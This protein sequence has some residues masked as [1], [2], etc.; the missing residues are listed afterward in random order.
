MRLFRTLAGLCTL[1]MLWACSDSDSGG[2]SISPPPPPP[3]P[4]AAIQVVH[5][6][7]NAPAVNVALDGNVAFSDV[8]YKE[9]PVQR[10]VSGGTTADVTVDA[11]LPDDTTM[12]VIT[13]PGA[14]FEAD[15]T[16]TIF[17]IGNVG[18]VGDTEL[19]A[20]TVERSQNFVPSDTIRASAVHAAANAPDV[21][22]YVSEAGLELDTID[23]I[24]GMTPVA[25]GDSLGPLDI[26]EGTLQVRV[27]L[28]GDPTALVFDSGPIAVDGG[29]DPILAA[30]DNTNVGSDSPI[31]ILI[32]ERNGVT[33]IQNIGT[34]SELRLTH[35]VPDVGDVVDWLI[36]DEIVVAGADF[37]DVE[38]PLELAPDTYV[39]QVAL[40]GM[41]VVNGP[42]VDEDG[43]P[44]DP[45]ET[46][47]G[48]GSFTDGFAVGS[49]TLDNL[50]LLTASDDDRRV[51]TAGKLRV[52]HASPS[53]E[54]VDLYVVDSAI[55]DITM[56][57]PLAEDI[58]YL[59]NS[60]YMEFTPGTYNIYITP[61][62]TKDIAIAAEGVD[63]EASGVYTAIARDP[64]APA[65]ELG[66]IL[67][68]DFA[69]N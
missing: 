62:G 27:T 3:P 54:G 37:T 65:M 6:S 22:I 69:N 60:G 43:D 10:T 31:S 17:A 36:D 66:L 45:V 48:I 51:A 58:P 41:V 40:D 38:E 24:N 67:M 42:T 57:D 59:F 34:Q 30:V 26:A 18:D 9:V 29:V 64:I 61:T 55:T 15:I 11:I 50:G 53:T 56:E 8:D 7:S 23:P 25:F 39:I 47:L 46:T 1:G 12:T 68:D 19:Q 20:V 2:G 21:D 4:T 33:E 44:V 52:I 63:L 35:A 49:V 28:A 5:G 13:V 32:V 14:T 16:Y